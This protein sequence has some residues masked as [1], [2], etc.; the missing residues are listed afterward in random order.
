MDFVDAHAYW[1]H[2]RFPHRPWDPRD[3]IENNKPMV[4]KPETSPLWSLAATRIAG[5]PFTVTEYNHVAP[6]EWQAECIPTIAAYAAL[7]DWDGVFLFAYSHADNY[8]KAKIAS[9]F[10]VEGNPLK[11][12]L[13][14]IGAR[15]FL[16]GDV[17]PLPVM[18]LPAVRQRMLQTG[19][20]YY[21]TVWPYVKDEL[22]MDWQKALK[23]G[24]QWSLEGNLRQA[25][26][27]QRIDWTA[28]GEGTGVITLNDPSVAARIGFVKAP[29]TLGPIE[30]TKL[31]SHFASIVLLPAESGKT[32]A[33]TDRLLLAIVGRGSNTGMQWDET[34]HTVGDKWGNPPAQIEVVKATVRLPPGWLLTPLKSDG[35]RGKPVSG[36]VS[37]EGSKTIWFEV[38]RPSR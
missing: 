16:R 17:K 31:D 15:I 38:T 23:C 25:L 22:E 27:D 4:D 26:M 2:P 18:T 13:M 36:E 1:D 5:K 19:S 8:D 12:P 29:T 10:D 28:S 14:P 35:A 32:L 6:N 21:Y 11:M 30:L 24:L 9:F 7:Q 20:K 37:L 33:D 34:R 3:W